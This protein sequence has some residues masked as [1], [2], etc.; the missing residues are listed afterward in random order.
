MGF[1]VRNFSAGATFRAGGRKAVD[2]GCP[3]FFRERDCALE[4][5]TDAPARHPLVAIRFY[6]FTK[7]PRSAQLLPLAQAPQ[8][9][10][11][12]PYPRS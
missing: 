12:L 2:D 11:A 5:G 4:Q 10:R 1:S 6:S 3:K 7:S 8:Q 9:A